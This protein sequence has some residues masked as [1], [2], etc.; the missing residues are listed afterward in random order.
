LKTIA[1][2]FIGLN[3]D[4]KQPAGD[5]D[6]AAALLDSGEVDGFPQLA[7][8]SAVRQE[9]LPASVA[10]AAAVVALIRLDQA[11][12]LQPSSSFPNHGRQGPAAGCLRLQATGRWRSALLVDQAIDS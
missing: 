9:S 8:M 1:S 7:L 11:P 2:C 5:I 12:A 4:P 6:Q 3:E 10:R